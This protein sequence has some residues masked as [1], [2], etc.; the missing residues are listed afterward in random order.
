MHAQHAL[1]AI[2]GCPENKNSLNRVHI[3]Y[4]LG[5]FFFLYRNLKIVEKIEEPWLCNW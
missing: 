1:V 2:Q 5:D 3:V 4:I